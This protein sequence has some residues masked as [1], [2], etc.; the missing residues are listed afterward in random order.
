MEERMIKIIINKCLNKF[1]YGI[2]KVHKDTVLANEFS[3]EGALFRCKKR[4]LEINTVIDVGASDGRWS[5]LCMKYFPNAQYLLFE[6]QE[7]H[8]QGLDKLMNEKK[9]VEYISAAAGNRNGVIF[10]DNSDL[11]GGLASES[12]FKQNCIQ[13][14]IARIDDEIAKRKLKPPFLIKLDTHGY[15]IPVLEGAMQSLNN[16]ELLIVETYNFKL[17]KTSLKYYQ[18]CD[19][20][21]RN[22][23]SSIEMV[24]FMLRGKD[25][26]FW[27]MDIFFIPSIR[28][29]FSS[30]SYI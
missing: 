2:H 27:Q 1:G 18:M 11:F 13:V 17:T 8:I 9:N 12:P 28:D 24:D 30:N 29:E 16:T 10:F 6:P 5:R 7:P 14:P 4:R 22:G 3:M 20:L 21:D 23:F 19:Y 25:K 26:S 15:E